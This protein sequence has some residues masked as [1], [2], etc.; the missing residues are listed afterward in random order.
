M[1]E[2]KNKCSKRIVSEDKLKEELS[3]HADIQSYDEEIEKY[4]KEIENLNN[5]LKMMTEN[6]KI[7]MKHL[8][9]LLKTNLN[10]LERNVVNAVVRDERKEYNKMLR[11]KKKENAHSEKIIKKT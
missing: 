3:K 8:R 9:Q 1:Y 7:R 5:D 2:L 6:Y 11:I 4:D 10:D